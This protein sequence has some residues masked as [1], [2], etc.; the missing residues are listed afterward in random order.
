MIYDDYS[1]YVTKCSMTIETKSKGM[2]S[3]KIHLNQI[4]SLLSV[5]YKDK[6]FIY[7][8]NNEQIMIAI[9]QFEEKENEYVILWELSNRGVSDPHFN[10]LP[11]NT[12]RKETKKGKEGLG[13][14]VHMILKKE[15]VS[16]NE[17]IHYF[18][19][20][21]MVGFGITY[22]EKA[23]NYIFK[24]F[25]D[26]FKY[27]DDNNKEYRAYPKVALCKF[28][29]KKLGEML[30]SGCLTGV[31]FVNYRLSEELDNPQIKKREESI[32]YTLTGTKGKK[33]L[34]WLA[35]QYNKLRKNYPLMT[36]IVN[37]RNSRQISQEI[38]EKQHSDITITELSNTP[39]VEREKV[40]L[41]NSIELCQTNFHAEL[42]EK[43]VNILYK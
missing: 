16:E 30:K 36:V 7:K 33:A 9:S 42:I 41:S 6:D 23:L 15:P 38:K 20:E 24:K 27:T 1:R 40:I 19:I 13:C 10:D 2:N 32:K 21:E 34:E 26:D 8:M 12:R 18:V 25:S 35:E 43:S 4:M 39:L 14:T 37:D 3:P 31:S 29:S 28:A 17:F 22:I 5:N 11:N